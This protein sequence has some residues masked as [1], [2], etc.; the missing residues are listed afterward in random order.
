MKNKLRIDLKH[1]CGS[2]FST[3]TIDYYN[4]TLG[5]FAYTVL[6]LPFRASL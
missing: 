1:E 2:N 3:Q 6:F 5:H 4:D